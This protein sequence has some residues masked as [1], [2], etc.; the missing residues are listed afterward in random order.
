MSTSFWSGF[1]VKRLTT[2][3]MIN[4]ASMAM[5]PQL[6]GDCMMAGKESRKKILAIIR[7]E[8]NRKQ[9]QQE[10]FVTFLEYREYI[11]GARKEPARAPQDTPI[12][13]AIKVTEDR[14]SVV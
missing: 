10:A 12:S 6:I 9:T 14:K 7:M 3:T 1:G 5:A 13:C 2:G 11:K 4:P 8:L